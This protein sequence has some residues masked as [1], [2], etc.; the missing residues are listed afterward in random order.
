LRYLEL[1]IPPVLLFLASMLLVFLAGR[2]LPGAQL[3]AWPA[4]DWVY[5][6]CMALA[7]IILMAAQWQFYSARTTLN[8]MNPG[9]ATSLLTKGVFA[10]SRNPVYLAM[11]LVV[12]AFALRQRHAAGLLVPVAFLLVIT[13]WQVVPEERQLQQRF[14]AAFTAYRARV[15]RWL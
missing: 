4:L 11:M 9:A 13:R 2:L 1:K 15:R 5:R 8:P 6:G 12:L 10:F 14:G 3:P 7:F